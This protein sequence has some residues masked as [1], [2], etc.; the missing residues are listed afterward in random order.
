MGW[1]LNT[2]KEPSGEGAP[3][4]RNWGEESRPLYYVKREGMA[5]TDQACLGQE[6]SFIRDETRKGSWSQTVRGLL[7]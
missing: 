1:A 5:K 3:S 6:V 2:G 7:S 4:I